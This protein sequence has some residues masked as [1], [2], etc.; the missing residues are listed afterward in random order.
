[1]MLSIEYTPTQE[2]W[3]ER[4][5]DDF[6]SRLQFTYRKDLSTPLNMKGNKHITSDT[7]WG[8]MLRTFQ[9]MLGQCLSVLQLGRNWRFTEESDLRPGSTYL[10]IV[11]LFMDL[12]TA[13]FSLY[14]FVSIGQR[15]L[16]K[17]P[18]AWFGPTSAAQAAGKLLQEAA[19]QAGGENPSDHFE[20]LQV[21]PFMR[22]VGCIVLD[23]G[24]VYKDLVLDTFQQNGIVNVI[25]LVCRQC[26]L[27]AFNVD[28]YKA[29]VLACFG[30]PQFMGLASGNDGSS[31]HYFVAAHGN[32]GL[33]YLDPHTTQPA[34]EQVQ[35]ITDGSGIAKGLRADRPLHLGW[36][37]LNPSLCMGFLVTSPEEFL[38][39]CD[40]LSQKPF[41]DVFDVLD[42]KPAYADSVAQ[43]YD[44]D[45]DIV[46]IG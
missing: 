26:G 28:Q 22:S 46:L 15:L 45:D 5:L 30:L 10:D 36:A 9:M 41:D 12:P 13:P 16:G 19:S 2:D 17:E 31:A 20:K 4:F 32:D 3:R 35:S 43:C 11:S 23:D 14:G 24:A 39:L 29:G 7:G 33:V 42:K 27:D 40:T 21:P 34:L 18:S 25:I 37:R 8:C 44:E 1:M 6:R 38:G